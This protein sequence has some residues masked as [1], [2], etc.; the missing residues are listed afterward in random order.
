MAV[1]KDTRFVQLN[2]LLS[3]YA[4][5]NFD[6]KIRVSDRLDEIDTI[7]MGINML[8]EELKERTISRDFFS[9][10]YNAVSEMIFVI[11]EEGFVITQ[12]EIASEKLGRTLPPNK[13]RHLVSYFDKSSELEMQWLG[14]FKDHS[15]SNSLKFEAV[16]RSS[17]RKSFPVIVKI[18]PITIPDEKGL[19]YLVVTEDITDKKELDRIIIEKVLEALEQE[20]KRVAYDLHDSLGQELSAIKLILESLHSGMVRNVDPARTQKSILSCAALL[21][22]SIRNLR[23]I[24]FNLLP[25]SLSRGNLEQ[26]LNE[27]VSRL[28][29]QNTVS[30]KLD[31]NPSFKR[32]S[33][34][35]ALNL[36]RITQ[37]FFSNTFKYA[38]ATNIFLS[39]SQQKSDITL[40]IEDNGKGFDTRLVKNQNGRGL[41]SMRTR[42][43]AFHG[44]YKLT[45]TLGKG[46]KL[47]LAISDRT[48]TKNKTNA[49]ETI[50]R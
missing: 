30:I 19:R 47:T 32:V 10:V 40:V 23:D 37:E 9:S 3:N 15:A 46:T 50:N 45:S 5:G 43:Q 39:L 25:D 12:N 29:Q 28:S 27:L 21:D 49:Y 2:E 7:L 41:I 26:A 48:S 44:K 31:I 34:E 36:F 38:E 20:Q 18:N 22:T 16:M 11:D 6:Y 14:G 17:S 8:G 35:L 24:C 42:A 4:L 33:N 13:K 1:K